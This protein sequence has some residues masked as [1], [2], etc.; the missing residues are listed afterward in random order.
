M[1]HYYT[2]MACKRCGR[3]DCTCPPQPDPRADWWVFSSGGPKRV[4]DVDQIA[5]MCLPRFK[6][7]AEAI[8]HGITQLRAVISTRE[9]Q[10]KELR[11]KLAA[12]E[13]G[14]SK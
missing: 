2:E 10:L 1:G 3:L 12:L 13:K 8:V 7:R 4:S 9:V 5:R 11:Q 14:A 6:T